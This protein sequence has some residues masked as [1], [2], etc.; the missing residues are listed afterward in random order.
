MASN[1]AGENGWREWSESIERKRHFLS[2]QAHVSASSTVGHA[3]RHAYRCDLRT[4][5][6]PHP[7]LTVILASNFAQG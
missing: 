2:Q 5:S 6:E 7:V 1:M 3:N 4:D